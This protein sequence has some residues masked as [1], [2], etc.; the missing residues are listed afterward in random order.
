MAASRPWLNRNSMLGGHVCLRLSVVSLSYSTICRIQRFYAWEVAISL[1]KTAQH[2]CPCSLISAHRAHRRRNGHTR[3]VNPRRHLGDRAV[4][5][6][7]TDNARPTAHVCTCTLLTK[8]TGPLCS[9]TRYPS[10]APGA[11]LGQPAARSSRV[12][13]RTPVSFDECLQ[14][15]HQCVEA[16]LVW[17]CAIAGLLP[18]ANGEVAWVLIGEGAELL[19]RL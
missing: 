10:T 8:G 15:S 7:H 9:G 2:F 3:A 5:S 12:F 6:T 11:T 13:T 18:V 19:A 14:K 16:R 17:W 1:R 4:R